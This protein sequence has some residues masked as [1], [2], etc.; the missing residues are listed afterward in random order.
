MTGEAA[1]ID[2]SDPRHEEAPMRVTVVEVGPR[3]GLQN[4]PV[5]IATA[6]KIAFVDLLSAA[7]LPVIE[8]TAFVSPKWI[9]QLAD[10]D[11]VFAAVTKRPGTRYT[12]L[13]PNLTGLERA[14]AAGARQVAIVAATSETFSRRN[15]NRT[16]D[17]S[18][19]AYRD[20]CARARE[21]GVAVRAYL[22]TA[23]G[24]PFEGPIAPARVVELTARLLALGV[25]EVAVSDTI[26]V[27]HPGHVRA[28][29]PVLLKTVPAERLAL[30]FHDTR[31]TALAN[32]LAALDF[33]IRTFD[34]SAGG[35]GGCPYAPGAAGNL[36]TEDL[37]YVLHGLGIETG[38]DLDA[39]LR[40]SA[41]I[42]ERI[43]RPLPS[44]YAQA[45]R[46]ATYR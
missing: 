20:V 45:A 18:M 8:V 1:T 5:T 38:V 35:L 34:A 3:D 6:D 10:A 27:A 29:L 9:P 44:R 40:A 14:L 37:L 7:G 4:E 23:F 24:C 30:H 42:E 36:A 12:A 39:L 22:S 25:F 43:G 16:I 11:Q 17:E 41:F 33:G 28:L 32:V 26:G 19:A 46:R 13:V 31:G 15:L 2:P 21:A